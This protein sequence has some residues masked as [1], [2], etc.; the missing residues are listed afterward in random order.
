MQAAIRIAV[1]LSSAAASRTV[2]QDFLAL[3]EWGRSQ[4]NMTIHFDLELWTTGVRDMAT[5]VPLKASDTIFMIPDKCLIA[6]ADADRH[7]STYGIFDPQRASESPERSVLYA[8]QGSV[9]SMLLPLY[10]LHLMDEGDEGFFAPYVRMLPKDV[11]NFVCLWDLEDEDGPASLLPFHTLVDLFAFCRKIRAMYNDISAAVPDFAQRRS[12]ADWQRAWLLANSRDI[13]VTVD[14]VEQHS[15]AP[16]LDLFNHDMQAPFRWD[17]VPG[18]I[19][20]VIKRTNASDGRFYEDEDVVVPAGTALRISYGQ[21][22]QSELLLYYGFTLPCGWETRWRSLLPNHTATSSASHH[23]APMD[24]AAS[25]CRDRL[26]LRTESAEYELSATH[27]GTDDA[28]FLEGVRQRSDQPA[29]GEALMWSEV[30]RLI[31]AVQFPLDSIEEAGASL[32]AA[33]PGSREYDALNV[34]VGQWSVAMAWISH[35]TEK[36]RDHETQ[37]EGAPSGAPSEAADHGMAQE[38]CEQ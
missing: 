21:Y 7:P 31:S 22:S 19:N 2:A 10:L 33:T 13:N 26:R 25:M 5:R 30:R 35:A 12:F 32:E 6:S 11:N 28:A 17:H 9:S 18:G 15:L 27:D 34:L 37:S 23:R 29:D 8:K 36:Q 20:S 4:C 24:A 14:G 1:V 38:A 16:V 3:V